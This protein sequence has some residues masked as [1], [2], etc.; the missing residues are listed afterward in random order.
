MFALYRF[1]VMAIT[2]KILPQKFLFKEKFA[3]PRKFQPSKFS[4]YT[5]THFSWPVKMSD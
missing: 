3:Q 5:V 1:D 4:G 2:S